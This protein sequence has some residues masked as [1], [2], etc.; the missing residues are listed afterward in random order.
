LSIRDRVDTYNKGMSDLVT[1]HNPDGLPDNPAFS[2]AVSVNAPHR[3]I[4]V[5]GQNA[6][7]ADGSVPHSDLR[8]QTIRTLENLE[9]VLADAGAAVT[10][11]VSWSVRVVDGQPLEDGFGG[12]VQFWG[13]RG[14]PPAIDFVAVA[15][16]A[17]PAYLVEISAIAVTPL[18]A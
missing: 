9:L 14:E 1:H 13:D 12:F 17:N 5:G 10:D 15:A 7:A 18:D 8:A 6:V 11:V 4:Y 3:T 2:Q 16:L